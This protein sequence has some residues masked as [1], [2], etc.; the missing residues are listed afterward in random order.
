M[1]QGKVRAEGKAE[2]KVIRKRGR[3]SRECSS[4]ILEILALISFQTPP[5]FLHVASSTQCNTRVAVW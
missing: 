5:M 1:A 3:G 4:N 2:A